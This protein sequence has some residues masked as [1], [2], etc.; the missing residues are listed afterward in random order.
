MIPH[1]FV[2]GASRSGTTSLYHCLRRHPEIYLHP[3]RKEARFFGHW[4]SGLDFRGP[5][6]EQAA[7]TIISDLASYEALFR[8][9]R[10]GQCI[11]DVSPVYLYLPEAARQIYQQAPAAKLVAMLRHPVERAFS[12][13]SNLRR[14]GIEPLDD[15]D[16]AMQAEPE[17]I[18]ARWHPRWHYRSR[19][20]Y[21][22]QLERYLAWFPSEQIRIY[23]TDDL[24]HD[25][26][27]VLSDLFRFLGVD[28]SVKIVVPCDYHVQ[29]HP[30]RWVLS[31]GPIA[32]SAPTASHPAAGA[33]TR[34]TRPLMRWLGRLAF[35]PPSLPPASRQ[36]WLRDYRED[37]ARLERMLMRDLSSWLA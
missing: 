36:R 3:H 2:I 5:R 6:D 31:R 7:A 37:I 10:P 26:Q 28:P 29:W 23:L 18:A 35:K 21:A 4:C 25:R 11:G 13:Y 1:F 33:V 34:G 8:E 24:R 16:R 15:F 22:R 17:R 9:A 20:F 19:G 32:A 27:A 12:S 30:R 14:K